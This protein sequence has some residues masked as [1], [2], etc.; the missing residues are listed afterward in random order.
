MSS[1]SRS[2]RSASSPVRASLSGGFVPGLNDAPAFTLTTPPRMS[3]PVLVAVSFIPVNELPL[4]A[5]VR[6]FT[7]DLAIST[8]VLLAWVVLSRLGL[9]QPLARRHQVQML[10]LFGLLRL[11]F[12]AHFL[13]HPVISGFI[14]GSAILI[15]V[16][17]L[18]HIFGVSVSGDSLWHM[19]PAL[20]RQ[21]REA[22]DHITFNDLFRMVKHDVEQTMSNHPLAAIRQFK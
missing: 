12:L 3:L 13:S 17:Q 11:G 5:Y 4:A 10:L 9:A 8:L 15:A 21:L 19:L 14:S 7:D 2:S 16:G 20:V 18:K 22:A 1:P 6:S